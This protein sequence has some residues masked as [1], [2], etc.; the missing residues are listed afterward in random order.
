MGK[1]TVCTSIPSMQRFS[2]PARVA[3]SEVNFVQLLKESINHSLSQEK[4]IELK[5]LAEFASPRE[6]IRR[7]IGSLNNP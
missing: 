5:S 6:T 2:P 4:I 1:S 7:I 3:K